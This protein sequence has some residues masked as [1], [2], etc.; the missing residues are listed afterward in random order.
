MALEEN[1]FQAETE[2]LVVT[3]LLSSILKNESLKG[4]IFYQQIV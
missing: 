1:L 2:N 4:N 3:E